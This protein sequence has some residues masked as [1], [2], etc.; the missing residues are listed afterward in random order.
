MKSPK[1]RRVE[2]RDARAARRAVEA[3]AATEREIERMKQGSVPVDKTNLAPSNS[4]GEPEFADRGYYVDKPFVCAEC[5]KKEIWSAG[6]Q[7]WWYE[8]AK[9]YVYSTAKLCRA[10]RKRER[11][12]KADARR[13]SLEGLARKRARRS[14]Q[15]AP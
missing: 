9:G 11:E 4:Y 12:R 6:Q 15:S 7:K 10:C 1:Q 3:A 2:I 14:D 13:V 8:V 5:G